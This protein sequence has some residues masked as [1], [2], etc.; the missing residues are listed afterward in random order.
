MIIVLTN[1]GFLASFDSDIDT[2]IGV[3]GS[4]NSTGGCTDVS[5]GIY[6]IVDD[7]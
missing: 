1:W 2:N 6:I 3:I 7:D 4:N 5:T